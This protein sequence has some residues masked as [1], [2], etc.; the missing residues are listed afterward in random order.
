MHQKN[1][2]QHAADLAML[3]SME[4]YHPL[5]YKETGEAKD[6][7]CIRVDGASDEGPSHVEVQLRWA[8]RHMKRPTKVTLVTT[9]SSGDSFLNRVEL[10]N[11]CLSRGHSNLFI[12]STL[13]GEP[14]DEDGQFDDS[15]HR[16][17]ME[18]ALQQYIARVLHGV[19]TPCMGTTISL[20]RGVG[21]HDLL[22]R[23]KRLLV[24]LKGSARDRAELKKTD[25]E[26][27]EYFAKVWQ[28][29]QNHMDNTLPIN[30]VY[31]LRCCG[32]ENCPHPLCAGHGYK[33]D[34]INQPS[35]SGVTQEVFCIC[36][37]PEGNFMIC[38][39]QCGQWFH[40]VLNCDSVIEL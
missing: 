11:G 30:Y 10:Q 38:C 3:Q 23:R 16:E 25:P 21:S 9:R 13:C 4:T 6:V 15:R 32:K 40:G 27:Y 28:V 29:R 14:Y 37:Q 33:G 39:D 17:N 36:R 20:H 19:P 24:F 1:P 34:D 31:L 7:E 8:E 35:D 5:F 26:E 18:A 12:P 22:E 2:C